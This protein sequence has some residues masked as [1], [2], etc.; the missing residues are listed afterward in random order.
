[1]QV[2]GEDN[3]KETDDFMNKFLKK[4][5]RMHLRGRNNTIPKK[6]FFTYYEQGGNTARQSLKKFLGD[7]EKIKEIE[8]KIKYGKSTRE[9]FKNNFN[10]IKKL[11][12]E[13]EDLKVKSK[14]LFKEKN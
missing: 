1:M 11:G 5:Y 14:M 3:Q 8:R 10:L 6:I 12:R 2:I 9:Q 7:I 4:T 13:L